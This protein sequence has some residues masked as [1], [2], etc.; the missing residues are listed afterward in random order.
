MKIQHPIMSIYILSILFFAILPSTQAQEI[1]I[2]EPVPPPADVVA[3][4]KLDTLFYEQWIDVHGFPVLASKKVSP[5]AVKEAVYLIHKMIG[6][7]LD[8]LKMFAQN[9]ERFSIIGYNETTTQIPEYSYLQP[10][11]Y[12]DIRTRGFRICGAKSYHKHQRGKSIAI[13]GGSLLRF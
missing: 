1:D 6:H 10:T 8:I 12:V 2:P 9:K 5:Y 3:A 13:S 4:F 7:R 11:F